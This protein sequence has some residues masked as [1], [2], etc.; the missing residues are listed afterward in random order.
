M[1]HRIPFLSTAV[2][3]LIEGL[4][5][6]AIALANGAQY[7]AA[8]FSDA[9]WNKIT[10]PHG[11]LFGAIIAIGVLWNAGRVRERNETKRRDKEEE[12]REK[13]HQELVTTNKENAESLKRLTVEGILAQAKATAAQE[14]ATVA[15]KDMDNSIKELATEL[16]GRPCQLKR[17]FETPPPIHQPEYKP[18]ASHE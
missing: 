15:I 13:R 9:D 4:L 12:A 17:P 16:S 1:P 3:N 8:V 6:A 5:L 18:A 7:I 2:S 10:G 14:R 11:F